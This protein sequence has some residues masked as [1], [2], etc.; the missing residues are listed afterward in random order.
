MKK[1]FKRYLITSAL[2]YANGPVHIGHLAG[3][4][5]PADI[6]VK[7]LKLK[8]K[9][10]V[11]VC[12]SD[13]HGVP[14]TITAEKE[15][16]SVQE[17]ANKY[18]EIIKKS[19]KDFG[20]SFDIYSRTSSQ[21]HKETASQFFKTLYDK[22]IL[23]ENIT[24]NFYDV[25]KEKF[26]ADRYIKGTCPRCQYEEAYGDQ[27]EKC[28]SSLNAT[29]LINPKSMLSN[30][31]PILKK[32]KHWYLPL[33]NFQKWLENWILLEHKDDWKQNVYQQCKSW[34]DAQL[35]PR[36]ITRDLSWGI[37]VPLDGAE[38]KVL[39]VWFDA[40]IGY[41]S[42][43][44]E[45]AIQN[46]KNW[47][48]YWKSEDTRLIHFIG[49]DNI[50]FHCIIFPSMLKSHGEYIMPDNIPAN[51]FLNLEGKKI[52][53]SKKWAIW[54]DDFIKKFPG[55]EDALRYAICSNLP[56]GRDAD[57]T[58]KD[59]QKK[60]NNE[61]IAVLGN[62]VNRVLVLAEKFLKKEFSILEKD[63]LGKY[64]K[65]FL[66]YLNNQK[67]NI[68]E[69][70]ENFRFKNA[71]LETMNITRRLNKYLDEKKPWSF[72]NED[73]EPDKIIF[74]SLQIIGNIS[75]LVYPFL[76]FSSKKI[77]KMIQL[78][79]Y[80][81]FWENIGNLDLV[82][83]N[84]NICNKEILFTKIEDEEIDNLIFG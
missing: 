74:F 9:D 27:C 39:Y 47:E 43:T 3:C 13:E 17:V 78:E 46:N 16:L 45:W 7:Y 2:P 19:L 10:V 37:P 57:F 67:K 61:L 69:S 49:K 70:L 12:G 84:L 50:V 8:K 82:K 48:L 72:S 15:S 65:D 32:T 56:E 41:I 4:F 59:F 31:K 20:I 25:E 35:Q 83:P 33:N 1:N 36:A 80:N 76:P 51:E 18:H 26:L 54:L 52:S 34:L 66:Q 62:V 5:L 55:R 22:G 63:L 44:K 6:Y 28:G 23:D 53:T 58:L 71:L 75:I 79:E 81:F 30:S 64:E 42:A 38:G 73:F 40:P 77:Q 11:F 29:D 24:D 68:E 21:L 60:N 14:I